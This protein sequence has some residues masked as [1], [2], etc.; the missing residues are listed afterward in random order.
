[1]TDASGP[2]DPVVDWAGVGRRLRK[3]VTIVGAVMGAGIAL[4][5]LV[6]G[7]PALGVWLFAGLAA[8]FVAEIVVVGGSAVRG[9]LRAGERGDR[10]ARP[11]VSLL[12]ARLRSWR[13]ESASEAGG[14]STEEQQP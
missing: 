4:T 13:Q 7:S 12:P 9:L 8:M 3:S 14:S 2:D 1:M 6:A 10:L 5:W 11:D